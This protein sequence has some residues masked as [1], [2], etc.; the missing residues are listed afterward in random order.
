MMTKTYYANPLNRYYT[1]IVCFA[2]I[3]GLASCG[4]GGKTD[5]NNNSTDTTKK[6]EESSTN[7][8]SSEGESSGEQGGGKSEAYQKMSAVI[9]EY[10]D[11]FNQGSYREVKTL[12]AANVKQYIT[13]KNTK[14]DAIAKS[15]N[16]FL[17]KKKFVDYFAEMDALKVE[18]KTANVPLN[19]KW[20]GYETR[21]L[22]EF[23]FDDAYKIVSLKEAKILKQKYTKKLQLAKKQIVK[24]YKNCNHKKKKDDCPRMVFDYVL[25]SQATN[26][27]AKDAINQ[28]ILSLMKSTVSASSADEAAITKAAEDFIKSFDEAV[29]DGSAM[30]SWYTELEV[31]VTEV[32]DIASIVCTSHG[33]GGGAHGFS[34]IFISHFDTNTGKKIEL[35]D[36]FVEGYL[37][38]LQKIATKIFRKLNEVPDG[39]TINEQGYSIDD[40]EKLTL[41]KAF[42]IK[43]SEF[44]FLYGRYEAGPYSMFPPMLRIKYADIKHLIKKDGLLGHKTK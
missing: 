24:T 3:F 27:K 39:K 8:T 6:A 20:T 38:K 32:K 23:E 9:Q 33:Y 22:T 1:F 40:N 16:Q 5:N 28:E 44:E 37:P 15:V 36:L 18:G 35:D 10:C 25:V 13:M 31:E 17:T 42:L 12:F 7:S 43:G 14:P 19:I 2:L 4:G 30:G 29:K 26:A 41:A 34:S 21:V 11:K